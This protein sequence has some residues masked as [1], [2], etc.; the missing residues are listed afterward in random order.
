ME[1]HNYVVA[2]DFPIHLYSRR[3][4]GSAALCKFYGVDGAEE[5]TKLV[6]KFSHLNDDELGQLQKE[7][8]S[9]F[10]LIQRL[11]GSAPRSKGS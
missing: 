7:V 1:A 4:R 3:C 8:N 6:G 9:S 2:L 11:V 10:S 5:F